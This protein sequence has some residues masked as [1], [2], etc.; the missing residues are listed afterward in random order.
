MNGASRYACST[1]RNKGICSNQLSIRRDELEA[2]VLDGLRKELMHPDLVKA[3]VDE[4]H[5]EVNRL[6]AERDQDRVHLVRDLEHTNRDLKRLVQAIKD[7]VAAL[8][9]KDEIMALE[10]SKLELEQALSKAPPPMPRLHPSLA[11]VYRQKVDNLHEALNQEDTRLEAADALR[12]LI[13]EI[14]LVPEDGKLNIELYGELAALIGLANKDPRSADR[15][16]Q[17]TL[18]AGAR[19]QPFRTPVSAFVPIPG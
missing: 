10:A 14:R 18:V 3:F 17:V 1:A 5:R 9:L 2:R 7:G 8:S 13:E 12:N 16:L 4:F 11:E 6:A 19:Y 15:G